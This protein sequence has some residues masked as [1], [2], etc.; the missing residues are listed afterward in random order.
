MALAKATWMKTLKI[1]W[2]PE[3]STDITLQIVEPKR[4]DEE[5]ASIHTIPA[6]AQKFIVISAAGVVRQGIRA[7]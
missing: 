3:T 2:S 4:E 6:K 7:A 1:Q 5:Q